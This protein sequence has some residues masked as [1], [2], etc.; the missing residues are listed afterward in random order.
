M[1]YESFKLDFVGIAESKSAS[2]WIYKCL[3]EHPEICGYKK[4]EAHFFTRF[5]D[6]GIDWY[7]SLFE[8]CPDRAVIGEYTPGYMRNRKAAERLHKHFPNVKLIACLRNPLDRLVSKYNADYVSGK[9]YADIDEFVDNFKLDALLYYS[10]LSRFLELFP[11]KNIL[12]LIYDDIAKDPAAFIQNIYRFLGVDDSFVPEAASKRVNLTS[13]DKFKYPAI[14][15]MVKRIHK[16]ANR[17]KAGRIVVK[18]LKSVGGKNLLRFVLR[19]NR[20]KR[21]GEQPVRKIM[22]SQE[23]QDMVRQYCREDIQKLEKFLDRALNEWK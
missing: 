15:R 16:T 17:R 5:Y 11:S 21:Q 7:V 22:P 18:T 20:T 23:K 12:V 10:H 19:H 8:H 1:S 2:T 14:N 4:K 6:K 9:I 3:L 13:R